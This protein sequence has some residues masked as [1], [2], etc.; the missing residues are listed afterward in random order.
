MSCDNG[1][2]VKAEYGD[3]GVTRCRSGQLTLTVQRGLG[4]ELVGPK[5]GYL[6]CTTIR[7]ISTMMQF[8][9]T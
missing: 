8:D 4:P 6:M 1:N 7:Y 2:V 3:V 9:S 5:T